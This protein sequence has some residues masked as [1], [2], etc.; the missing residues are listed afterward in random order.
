MPRR[1]IV[2][3]TTVL[4]LSALLPSIALAQDKRSVDAVIIL[5]TSGPMLDGF[6]QFCAAYPKAIEALQRRGLDLQVTI[7]GITRPYACAVNTVRSI[8]GSTVASDNDWGAAVADVAAH[9]AWRPGSLRVIVPLSNR[10]PAMG[11][12]VDDPGADRDSIENAIRAAQAMRVAV[13]PVLGAPDRSTQPDDRSKL[14]RLAKD[15]AQATN[16]ETIFLASNA[17]DPTP[18]IMSLIDA[19]ANAGSDN[20]LLLSIPAAIFTLTCQRD[21]TKCISFNPAVLIT[22]AVVTILIVVLAGTSTALFAASVAGARLP[23]LK[24]NDRVKNALSTGKQRVRQGYRSIFA[25]E[26]WSIGTPL[27]RRLS[28]ALLIAVFV[29]LAA[30]LAAFIDPQFDSRSGRSIAIFLSLFISIGLVTWLFAR[31]QIGAA[32]GTGFN[33]ALRVR[34]LVLLLTMVAVLVTRFID[35]LPGFIVVLFLSYTT[36]NASAGTTNREWRGAVRGLAAVTVVAL[37]T[38]LLAAPLDL[39]IG[40]LLAQVG[41]AAAQ[42]GATALGLLESLILT[43][44][45]V[46]LE[47]A[48]FSLLPSRITDGSRIFALNRVLWGVAFALVTYALLATAVNPTLSGVEVFRLPAIITIG[49]ILLVTSAIALAAWLLAS[50]R[51]TGQGRSPDKRLM[52]SA[53]VLLAMWVFV[54]GCGAIYLIT[55]IGR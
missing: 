28:S 14:E 42:T 33:A 29:G 1:L 23:S 55:R 4:I 37:A 13:S 52:L 16:G 47:H 45:I 5:D 39:L 43:I 31:S 8:A 36:F 10:G 50:D 44:Y 27:I 2:L 51:V 30:L 18:D 21:V 26:S 49:A 38:W 19:T 12:P 6:D 48:F 32:K 25:P 22:N 17:N 54:C 7:L 3:L 15:L 11:D 41:I 35:F 53:I 46:A 20:S 34:P 24:V 40:N 9:T